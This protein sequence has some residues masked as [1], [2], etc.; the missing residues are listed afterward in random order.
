MKTEVPK[1]S[2]FDLENY[3]FKKKFCVYDGEYVVSVEAIENSTSVIKFE[4][5]TGAAN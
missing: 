1:I 2:N 3:L 4:P 5:T